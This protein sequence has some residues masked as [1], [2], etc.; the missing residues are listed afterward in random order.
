MDPGQDP[1]DLIEMLD[2]IRVEVSVVHSRLLGLSKWKEAITG[3]SHD[4]SNVN[5]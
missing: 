5:R 1:N 3:I 2:E 4:L